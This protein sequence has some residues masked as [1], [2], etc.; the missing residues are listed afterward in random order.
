MIDKEKG[1]MLALVTEHTTSLDRL[2]ALALHCAIEILAARL[3][4]SSAT[5]PGRSPPRRAQ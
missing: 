3:V 5:L 1:I 2:L 4:V